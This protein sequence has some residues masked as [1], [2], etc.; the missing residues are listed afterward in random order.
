M[1]CKYKLKETAKQELK[2]MLIAILIMIGVFVAF[3]VIGF[4]IDYIGFG[5]S[6]A[7]LDEESAHWVEYIMLYVI[8]GVGF[9]VVF[10]IVTIVGGII[11]TNLYEGISNMFE[12]CD[13]EKEKD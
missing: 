6:T 8:N 2:A 3:G 10:I 11:F 5:F 13:I 9:L 4:A 7:R 1:V 12:P